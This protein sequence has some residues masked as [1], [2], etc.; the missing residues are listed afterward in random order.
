MNELRWI[1]LAAGVLLIA[2]IYFWGMRRR[3]AQEPR[4]PAAFD[5]T[6]APE[7]AEA[8][9]APVARRI[10]PSVSLDDEIDTTPAIERRGEPREV[11]E[12]REGAAATRGRREPTLSAR[13]EPAPTTRPDVAPTVRPEPVAP[14]PVAPE[15]TRPAPERPA[16]EPRP[17]AAAAPTA[18]PTPAAKPAAPAAP[19][20]AAEAPK[21][22]PKRPQ[23]IYA[24]R[25]MANAPEK[26]PG[27]RVLEALQAEGLQFGKYQ[28]FHRMHETG[29]PLFSVASLKDQGVFD[30]QEMP[31]QEFPGLLM[32]TVLP[33]PAGASEA[34]D[35]MLFTARAL[36]T[37]LGGALADDQGTPLTARRALQLRDEAIEFERTVAGA[38]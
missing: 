14:S 7:P 10:E 16:V 34:F 30:V 25:V 6:P 28:I 32:F 3:G 31:Q 8:D 21:A 23:K 29:R 22:R 1:L 9:E 26:F 19:A 33:G 17:A 35:E 13:A 5:A 2:G 11:G 15:T 18:T 36:A 24:V 38:V 20:A 12:L 27:A 4:R 37:H